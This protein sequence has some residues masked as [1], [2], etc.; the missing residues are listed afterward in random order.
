MDANKQSSH[1]MHKIVM[2]QQQLLVNAKL[3]PCQ[4]SSE[5]ASLAIMH[6]A[7]TT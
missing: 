5:A 6:T 1:L 3:Q 7:G 2:Q 4:Q